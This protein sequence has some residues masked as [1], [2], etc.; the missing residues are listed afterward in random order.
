VAEE[1]VVEGVSARK[2]IVEMR[3]KGISPELVARKLEL[4]VGEVNE[5]FRTYLVENYSELGEV[6]MRL[7]QMAR[8]ESIVSFIW[9]Q[10]EEGDYASEGRQTKNL[11]DVIKELNTLLGLHRDP[12]RDAKVEL[13]NAQRDLAYMIISQM[14]AE[15]LAFLTQGLRDILGR[16]GGSAHLLEQ[17]RTELEASWGRWYAEAYDT[18]V[19]RMKE[20]EQG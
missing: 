11:L 1:R 9:G 3:L 13:T 4:S 10:V 5:T 19:T 20:V 17:V 15:L 6:E 14:R 12:L 18:S 7:T 2:T 8:L 16:N